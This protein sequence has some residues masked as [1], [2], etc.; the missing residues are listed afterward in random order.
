MMSLNLNRIKYHPDGESNGNI[1]NLSYQ[2]G[3][4]NNPHVDKPTPKMYSTF[5]STRASA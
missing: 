5:G 2:M 1:G 3:Y 4:K